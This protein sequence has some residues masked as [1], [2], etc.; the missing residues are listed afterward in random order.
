MQDHFAVQGSPCR[1]IHMLTGPPSSH[2][3]QE[4]GGFPALVT[5][6]PCILCCDP[7]VRF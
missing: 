2:L 7:D 1:N 4:Y 6:S 3:T 5:H